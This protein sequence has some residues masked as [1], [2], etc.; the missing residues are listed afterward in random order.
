MTGMIRKSLNGVHYCPECKTHWE[1][2]CL[3]CR[4]PKTFECRRCYWR[5]QGYGEI[6]RK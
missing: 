6:Y 4:Y 2:G 1:C 3:R 5:K